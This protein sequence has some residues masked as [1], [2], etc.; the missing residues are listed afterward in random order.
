MR[1]QHAERGT[2]ARGILRYV[3]VFFTLIAGSGITVSSNLDPATHFDHDWDAGE[4]SC[5]DLVLRLRFRLKAM[6]PGEVL[7]V[8]ALDP[9]APQD[10]PAWC[11]LTGEVLVH[12]DARGHYYYIRRASG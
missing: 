10:L 2:D 6:A 12:H 7:R 1:P 5:G 9:G 11:R 3:L 4:L 8:R